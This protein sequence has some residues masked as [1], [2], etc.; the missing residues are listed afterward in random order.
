MLNTASGVSSTVS[1]GNANTANSLGSTVG[2]GVSN[3]ASGTRSTVD[4]GQGNTASGAFSTVGGGQSNIAS[5]SE[6]TIG[7][8]LSN[9]ASGFRSAIGG[10][11]Q[12]IASH[13]YSTVPGGRFNTAGGA[14]SFAAGFNA[15]VRDAATTGD[16]DGDEGTFVWADST[17]LAFTSTGPDQFLIRATG[18]VGIGIG[19]NPPTEALDVDGNIKASGTIQSGTSIVIDGVTDTITASS[20]TLSFDNEDLVTTGKVGIGTPTPCFGIG[21][22]SLDVVGNSVFRINSADLNKFLVFDFDCGSA[23]AT[24]F[25]IRSETFGLTGHHLSLGTRSGGINH[26]DQLFLEN[27]GRVGIGTDMPTEQLDVAG[28]IHASGTIASGTSIVID[29]VANTISSSADMEMHTASGRV[30]RFEDS[31]TSPNLIGGF[32]GNNVTAGV[33]GATI[34]GGG[35]NLNENLVTDNYSTIGGGQGNQAGDG[36]GSFIDADFATV[37]GGE[38][39]TASDDHA[40]VG[41]GFTNTASGFR[42]TVGGGQLNTASGSNS[43]V[44][45]GISNLASGSQTTVGGGHSNTAS[46]THASTVAGGQSNTASAQFSTVPGGNSNTAA[47]DYSFAAGRRAKVR[48][49]VATGDIDGDEGTFVWADSTDADFTSTGSDQFLIRASGGVAIGTN[50][51]AGSMLKVAGATGNGSVILPGDA[52]SA[53]E[54][55]DEPGVASNTRSSTGITLNGTLQTLLERVINV[56]T[57]GH[58]LVIGSLEATAS[59]TTGTTSNANFG[60]SD[61]NTGFPAN[62][63]IELRIPK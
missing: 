6:A 48:D 30:L 46:G 49:T 47:G 13:N 12:N 31:A 40:T 2:G 39:N 7:G 38:N 9:N 27:S 18:G 28:N 37:G 52:I 63:D 32:N 21:A 57:S 8:G 15:E 41:G 35:L 61:V 55:L 25:R 34:G 22:C 4:G 51:P 42:S 29:G 54:T 1:G 62:Q 20:G 36:L 33:V 19:A 43:T 24:R 3:I 45:G 23:C 11:E 53:A 14:F 26:F 17:N 60:V 10:G 58:V 56:P 44:A 59:H 5:H 50:D 16:I